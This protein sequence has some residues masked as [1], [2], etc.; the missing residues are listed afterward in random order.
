MPQE[1]YNLS[2]MIYFLKPVGFTSSPTRSIPPS[3]RSRQLCFESVGTMAAAGSNK[4]KNAKLVNMFCVRPILGFVLLVI[5]VSSQN[6]FFYVNS[7][8]NEFYPY[9]LCS[10]R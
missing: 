7:N 2:Y 10:F 9:G 8:V 5:V 4:I 1:Y 6:P 3:T